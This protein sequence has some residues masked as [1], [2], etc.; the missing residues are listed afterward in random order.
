MALEDA[1]VLADNLKNAQSVEEGFARYQQQRRARAQRV[2]NA[3]SRNARN[4][5]LRFPPSRFMAHTALR[6]AGRLAPGLALKKFDWLYG[7]DVTQT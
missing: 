3:A 6:I 4:Y 2:V 7:H 5:H 1:W